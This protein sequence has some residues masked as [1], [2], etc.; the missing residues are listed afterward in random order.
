MSKISKIFKNPKLKTAKSD[1]YLDGKFACSI[2]DEIVYKCGLYEGREVDEKALNEV[3]IENE[4]TVCFNKAL[5]YISKK[6]CSKFELVKNLKDKGFSQNAIE[7][8]A[9][10]LIDYNYIN[11][12]EYVN[13]YISFNHNKGKLKIK[14][15][16]KKKGVSDDLISGALLKLENQDVLCLVAAKKYIEKKPDY[17]KQSLYQYLI[18]KGFEY[19]VVA[20][21]LNKIRSLE[22]DE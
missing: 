5:N 2:L 1:I 20:A 19:D 18:T 13:S 3:L 14:Y 12:S 11:D 4:K 10:K 6:I 17:K 16:L 7:N 21:A 15:E 9:N 22:L 8:A